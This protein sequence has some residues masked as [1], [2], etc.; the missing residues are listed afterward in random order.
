MSDGN[1]LRA[2][3]LANPDDDTLRLV[4]ADWLQEHDQDWRAEFIRAQVAVA[5]M[6][7]SGEACEID[8]NE[9]HTCCEDPCPVC[10]S[11]LRYAALCD[12]ERNAWLAGACFSILDE[13]RP[14]WGVV[15]VYRECERPVYTPKLPEVYTRR[16]FVES[17][18]CATADWLSLAN[19]ILKAHPVRRVTLT[20]LLSEHFEYCFGGDDL[21]VILVRF[22]GREQWVDWPN[23]ES[24][25]TFGLRLL[26]AEW[27][28]VEFE[29]SAGVTWRSVFGVPTTPADLAL[30]HNPG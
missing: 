9:G 12:Q 1:D 8:P 24:A 28:D 19:A 11:V 23:D 6:E 25:R 20:T 14:I 21:A 26:K 16:G 17:V 5:Q 10:A 27:P 7:E 18:T 29:L 2:Q 22:Q 15:G 13:M 4:Y 3:I 30:T